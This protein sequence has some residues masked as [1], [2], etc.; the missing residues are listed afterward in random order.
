MYATQTVITEL[1]RLAL[2]APGEGQGEGKLVR[3][4]LAQDS[5]GVSRARAETRYTVEIFMPWVIEGQSIGLCDVRGYSLRWTFHDVARW[6][7]RSLP[8]TFHAVTLEV[9]DA[10]SLPAKWTEARLQAHAN[11]FAAIDPGA[12]RA[13]AAAKAQKVA[14]WVESDRKYAILGAASVMEEVAA[15]VELIRAGDP[16]GQ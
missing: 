7:S 6:L 8:G 10:A 5:F 11:K 2:P 9:L 16:W 3:V 1:L 15:R 14:G 4:V 12:M 13:D